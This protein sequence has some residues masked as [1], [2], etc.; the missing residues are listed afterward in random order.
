VVEADEV[1]EPVRDVSKKKSVERLFASPRLGG[2]DGGADD[3][4]AE[5]GAG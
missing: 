4:V 1:A 5:L 3:D 2:N